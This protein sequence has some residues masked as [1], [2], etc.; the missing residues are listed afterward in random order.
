MLYALSTAPRAPHSSPKKMAKGSHVP[1]ETVKEQIF[2]N[3]ASSTKD[4]AFAEAY[5]FAQHLTIWFV[6][7]AQRVKG[8]P[9][10]M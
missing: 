2:Q 4:R 3:F 9:L 10:L 7:S 1:S 5:P 8:H 6:E